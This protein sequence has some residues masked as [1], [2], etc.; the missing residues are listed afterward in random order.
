MNRDDVKEW[1]ELPVPE[2]ER[3]RT[4]IFCTFCTGVLAAILL[5]VSI[6]MLNTG[7]LGLMQRTCAR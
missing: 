1:E 3:G 5:V 7:R 2:S 4:D 6:A